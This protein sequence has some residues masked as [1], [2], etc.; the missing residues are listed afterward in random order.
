[1]EDAN[2]QQ[3]IRELKELVGELRLAVEQL[4]REN[5]HLALRLA[6]AEAELNQSDLVTQPVLARELASLQK[7]VNSQNQ[8]Q[9]EILVKELTALIKS[10]V[11]SAQVTAPAT[12]PVEP[13]TFDENY[14]KNGVMYQVRPGDTISKI[15]QELGSTIGY[16]K[17]ANKIADPKRLQVGDTLF[18][19]IPNSNP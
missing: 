8:K 14:P 11:S 7:Q 17:N 19:P 13:V 4:Q 18:I 12:T 1:M 15:A 5:E 16:I 10:T 9:Q 6:R 3:D 2:V